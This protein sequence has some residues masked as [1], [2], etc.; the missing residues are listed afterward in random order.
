MSHNK[1]SKLVESTLGSK[2]RAD[3]ETFWGEYGWCDGWLHGGLAVER[4][5][6]LLRQMASDRSYT[7]DTCFSESALHLLCGL[8]RV[9]FY[10]GS[11]NINLPLVIPILNRASQCASQNSQQVR[12]FVRFRLTSS[13]SSFPRSKSRR[14]SRV[15]PRRRAQGKSI[16]QRH[17]HRHHRQKG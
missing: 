13:V 16:R 3:E 11:N 10:F 5:T 12:T 15:P 17:Q 8:H 7:H 1:Q 14:N 9:A 4:M 2:H 6:Y